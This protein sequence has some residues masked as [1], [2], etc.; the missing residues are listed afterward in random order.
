MTT[1]PEKEIEAPTIKH[2]SFDKSF[3]EKIVHAL[4]FDKSW[5]SQMEEVLNVDFF[6]YNYLK[7]IANKY[8]SYHKKYK[9]YPSTELLTTI[10][11]EELN[12]NKDLA[13]RTQ[14]KDFLVK[15]AKNENLN[16]LPYVKERSLEF[17]KK[18]GLQNALESCV[19]LIVSE[20]YDKVAE[21]IKTALS[22]GS[23]VTPGLE[24]TN[25]D[26]IDARYSET[27]RHT[28][29]TGIPELDKREILNGGLGSGEIGIIVAPT[30]VGKSHMLVHMSAQALMQGKNVIYY[31]LELNERAVGIRIDSHLTDIAS[32]DCVD[33]KEEIKKHYKDNKDKYGRLVVKYYPTGGATVMT[34][35]NH[36]E[37]LSITGFR[38]DMIVIDYSGI[39]RSSEK[40]DAPRFEL[41]KVF[42]EMRAMA[43]ELN[44][45]LW[46]AVQSNKEGANLENVGLEQFSESYGQAH[47]CDFVIGINRKQE[48]KAS[49]L[50]TVY[51]A[52][53]RAGLDGIAFKAHLDTARSKLKALSYED[54]HMIENEET[55][56]PDTGKDFLRTTYK[57]MQ[58]KKQQQIKDNNPLSLSLE[59]IT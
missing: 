35:R 22:K 12:N 5:A 4:I 20:D 53:N 29:G 54:L 52:K 3:Q 23:V 33:H 36:I 43:G 30:G 18:Q 58:A 1:E 56:K 51:I 2:F 17:C 40:Y 13:L 6:E 46:S 50:T 28:I 26:D 9:E 7:L 16:D 11:V 32:L 59:K 45:P 21:V 8:I 27:Y 14:I 38:P 57:S 10:L 37:R 44:I 41:K 49:G 19:E 47:V 31:T 24:L 39:L 25:E 15:V 34:L 42:E 55:K 48:H